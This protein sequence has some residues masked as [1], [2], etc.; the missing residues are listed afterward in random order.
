MEMKRGGRPAS[1]DSSDREEKSSLTDTRGLF[2]TCL[3]RLCGIA[4]ANVIPRALV[5]MTS[6]AVT[7][8]NKAFTFSS[9]FFLLHFFS[10]DIIEE[11]C[12][13]TCRSGSLSWFSLE[14]GAGKRQCMTS[15]NIC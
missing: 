2:K 4:R 14:S 1:L 5:G 11:D 6:G 12:E 7:L 13:H 10:R 3:Q 8:K 9:F 15:H